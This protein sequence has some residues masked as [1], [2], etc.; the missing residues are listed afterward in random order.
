MIVFPI[1]DASQPSVYTP[2]SGE[3]EVL[4]TDRALDACKEGVGEASLR[5]GANAWRTA[6]ACTDPLETLSHTRKPYVASRAFYK[7]V[8][9]VDLLPLPP[10]GP[11]LHLC[12]APGGFVQAAHDMY[13]A[14]WIAHS[15]QVSPSTRSVATEKPEVV[16]DHSMI[17]PPCAS[18]SAAPFKR[19]PANGKVLKLAERGDLLKPTPFAQLVNLTQLGPYKRY[20]LVTADGSVDFE[21]SHANAETENAHLL[22]RQA[23]VAKCALAQ[24]GCFVLKLFDCRT[25]ATMGLVQLVASWFERTRVAK[26]Q[27]SRPTNGERYLVC[28]G[29]VACNTALI[30]PD[31]SLPLSRV[32][33]RLDPVLKRDLLKAEVSLADKQRAALERAFHAL[34]GA[35]RAVDAD[36]TRE[37][38]ETHGRRLG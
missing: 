38:M 9:L 1:R 12:D 4:Y 10:C 20:G 13:G 5:Y 14:E 36:S 17:R 32:V 3:S 11:F 8:E 34:R 7:L 24:G 26:P 28:S 25:E 31:P 23:I 30:P 22:L 18:P 19:V 21:H 33:H 15:L 16:P 6:V 2:E 35:V 29:F 27:T 37:W